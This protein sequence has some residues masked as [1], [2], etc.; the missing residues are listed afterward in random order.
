MIMGRFGADHLFN[1]APRHAHLSGTFPPE[2]R[3]RIQFSMNK[4]SQN[5]RAAAPAMAARGAPLSVQDA[6]ITIVTGHG[7]F[8]AFVT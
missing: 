1:T 2:R 6:G 3:G 4:A 8:L 5:H 7:C